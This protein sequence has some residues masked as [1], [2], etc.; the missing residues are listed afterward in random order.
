[1]MTAEN[2]T[3]RNKGNA[4]GPQRYLTKPLHCSLLGLL[5]KLDRLHDEGHVDSISMKSVELIQVII[6]NAAHMDSRE[7]KQ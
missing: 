3:H 7:V 6:A 5:N 4:R 2:K 1:M